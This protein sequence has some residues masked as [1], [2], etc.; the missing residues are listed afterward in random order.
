MTIPKVLDIYPALLDELLDTLQ[1][2]SESK[3]ESKTLLPSWRIKDIAAHIASG[4]IRKLSA[5]RNN[6]PSE[7]SEPMDYESLVTRINENNEKW[8]GLLRNLHFS[9]IIDLLTRYYGELIEEFKIMDPYATA[10]HGVAWAGELKSENWFDIAREY[11]ELW[12]HQMQIKNAIG[13]AALL[14]DEYYKPFIDTCFRALPYHFRKMGEQI[15]FDLLI[16]IAGM[17]GGKYLL[18]CENSIF[19][20]K[21]NEEPEN[22]QDIN[23]SIHVTKDV[24]WKLLTNAAELEEIKDGISIDGNYEIGAHFGK[25]TCI[26]I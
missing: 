2:L 8:V 22:T 18:L 21:E 20:I 14:G 3:W 4:A 5:I 25:M 17:N 24:L 7:V 12:H 13:D 15:D 23:T 11:T 10:V 6:E 9:L 19:R 1:S 26:M 16:E